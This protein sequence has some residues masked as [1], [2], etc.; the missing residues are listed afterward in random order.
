M[1]TTRRNEKRSGTTSTTTPTRVAKHDAAVAGPAWWCSCRVVAGLFDSR[2]HGGVVDA[3]AAGDREG[4]GR[5]DD[6]DLLYAGYLWTA[7][8]TDATQWS[9]V[10]PVTC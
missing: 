1:S 7:W 2:L 5:E 9:Q 6:V 4:S 3:L 8:V 10:I